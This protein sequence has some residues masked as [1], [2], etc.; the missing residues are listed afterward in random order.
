[1]TDMENQVGRGNKITHHD[2]VRVRLFSTSKLSIMTALYVSKKPMT[3]SEIIEACDGEVSQPSAYSIMKVLL[4]DGMIVPEKRIDLEAMERIIENRKTALANDLAVEKMSRP[5]RASGA[6]RYALTVAGRALLGWIIPFA[7]F[8]TNERGSEGIKNTA[9]AMW[10]LKHPT[11][12]KSLNR[13][14]AQTVL[15]YYRHA[16]IS[17][18]MSSDVCFNRSAALSPV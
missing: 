7:A 17:A 6:G 13:Q 18:K 15:G 3:I 16:S 4:N 9:V 1:M 10:M 2:P 11:W 12:V 5:E 8:R 14:E